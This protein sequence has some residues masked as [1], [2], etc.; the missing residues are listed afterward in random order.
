[1]DV[2][3]IY[4]NLKKGNFKHISSMHADMS[5]P[6]HKRDSPAMA[7]SM[8]EPEYLEHRHTPTDTD[9]TRV[10]IMSEKRQQAAHLIQKQLE[11]LLRIAAE[12]ELSMLS[13]LIEMALLEAAGTAKAKT[14][15]IRKLA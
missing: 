2:M 4:H 13:Y 9:R 5:P 15:E 12:N 7:I 1:M 10:H 11:D 14:P 3:S 8:I 6:E